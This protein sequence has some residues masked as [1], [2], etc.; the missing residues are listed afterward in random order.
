MKNIQK[1]KTL[2]CIFIASKL[3]LGIKKFR[4]GSPV[5]GDRVGRAL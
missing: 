3:E 1:V 4:S 5:T 2:L